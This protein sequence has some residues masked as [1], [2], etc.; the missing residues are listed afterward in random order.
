MSQIRS[1][2]INEV[3]SFRKTKEAFGGL[4]NMASGYSLNINGILI[5]TTE[6]LYQACRF[7]NHPLI[8]EAIIL[9][10]SPMNAKLISRRN[11][12]FTRTD[13]DTI[14]IKLMK[15]CLEIKLSQNWDK[16]SKLLLETE[17]KAIVEFTKKDKM[18]GAVQV[19]DNYVGKNALGR[20]LMGIREDYVK[21]GIQPYCI[22]PPSIPNFN[23]FSYSIEV[24]CNSA[25]MAELLNCESEKLS[26]Y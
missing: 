14:R 7:P 19:G 15:W 26:T 11:T 25:Y 8:Q 1:Y 10:A 5:P 24:V 21:K 17:N 22:E 12:E 18:W 23:L 4:S 9:E 16:F 2:P 13:W 6:H 20:L 3:I